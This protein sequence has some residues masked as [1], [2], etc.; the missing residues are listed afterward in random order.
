MEISV[1]EWM[2]SGLAAA[3]KE[4]KWTVVA[5]IA[6]VVPSS[7]GPNFVFIEGVRHVS[8]DERTV[9]LRGVCEFHRWWSSQSR[10]RPSSMFLTRRE[11]GVMIRQF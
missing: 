2:P 4:V 7:V 1:A 3:W 9:L 10:R 5:N 6:L 11:N 8:H